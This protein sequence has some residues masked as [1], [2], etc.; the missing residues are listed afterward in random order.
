MSVRPTLEVICGPMGVGK[1]TMLR[2]RLVG[3][4][5]RGAD[6]LAVLPALD[7]RSGNGLLSHDGLPFPATTVGSLREIKLFRQDIIGIDE[8]HLFD[9]VDVGW[10]QCVLECGTHLIV[11]G[12]A[13]DS[14][15]R[16]FGSMPTFMA[17]A[18]RMHVLTGVCRCGGEATMTRSKI[19]KEEKIQIGGLESYEAVCRQCW[20][21]GYVKRID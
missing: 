3:H 2:G 17:M 6:V 10:V 5:A 21:S 1:T 11:S 18:D 19:P 4:V 16:P 14:D 7:T 12:L 8:A 20:I 15:G 9:E 13:T